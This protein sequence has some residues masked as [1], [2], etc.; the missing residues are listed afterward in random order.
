MENQTRVYQSRNISLIIERSSMALNNKVGMPLSIIIVFSKMHN[1]LLKMFDFFICIHYKPVKITRL[2]IIAYF[3]FDI[4]FD[5]ISSLFTILL[6]FIYFLCSSS[7]LTI[8]LH[9]TKLSIIKFKRMN[10]KRHICFIY[11]SFA[12]QL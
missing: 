8:D 4:Q 9:C 10:L 3:I 6:C 5:S 11:K 7:V 12:L 1:L 2:S